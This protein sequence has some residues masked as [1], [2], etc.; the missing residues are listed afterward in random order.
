MRGHANVRHAPHYDSP[1]AFIG[2]G[3]LS[4]GSISRTCGEYRVRGPAA[5]RF[6]S[7]VFMRRVYA[8]DSRA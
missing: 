6:A 5:G 7:A 3:A 4:T 1:L 8:R 2:E